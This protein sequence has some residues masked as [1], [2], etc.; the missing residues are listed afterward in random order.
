[1]AT[2]K[3]RTPKKT[4]PKHPFR[5]AAT[6]SAMPKPRPRAQTRTEGID[7]GTR[8]WQLAKLGGGMLGGALACAL[9]AREEWLPPKTVT[10]AA[11]AVGTA[12]MVGGESDTARWLGAGMAAATGG[13]LLLLTVDDHAQGKPAEK[14]ASNT[15]PKKP[16]NADGLPPGALEAAYE[17]ARRRLAMTHAEDVAA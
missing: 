17:R 11:A 16:A 5:N 10:G 9:I 1:M 14:L 3:T 8:G 2:K 13:Q 4:K 15:P 6:V 12:L 7:W